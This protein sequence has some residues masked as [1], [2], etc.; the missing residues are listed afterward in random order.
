M[1][2]A[3]IGIIPGT[4]FII[5]SD[6]FKTID[7]T[8]HQHSPELGMAL[9]DMVQA[10]TPIQTGALISD[11][12]D[13][14]YTSPGGYVLGESDVVWV[15]ANDVAQ[16]AYWNRYYAPYQ[17]GGVLGLATYTNAPREMFFTTAT[18]D[19]L[20]FVGAWAEIWVG[21]ALSISAGGG[22][23]PFIMPYITGVQRP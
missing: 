18:T 15:Y 11:I 7:E 12:T 10:I 4:G 9:K 3:T 21:E 23:V 20:D 5:N 13:E 16:Q 17:E 1:N 22:G 2:V 8:L 19:G 6:I 14:E